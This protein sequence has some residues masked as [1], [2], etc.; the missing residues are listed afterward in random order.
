[1]DR[2]P[3]SFTARLVA[4]NTGRTTINFADKTD[5]ARMSVCDVTVHD[6]VFNTS[7]QFRIFLSFG[8]VISN[9]NLKHVL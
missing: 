8:G 4:I 3:N 5:T 1:M 6:V 7:I 9:D 2:I